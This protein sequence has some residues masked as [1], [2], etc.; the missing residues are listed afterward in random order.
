MSVYM[1]YRVCGCGD[2]YQRSY[3]HVDASMRGFCNWTDV[4]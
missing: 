2:L 1:L 4:K 3:S